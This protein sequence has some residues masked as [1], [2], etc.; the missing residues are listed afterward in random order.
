MRSSVTPVALRIEQIASRQHWIIGFSE[1][2]DVGMPAATIVR[3]AQAGH[4][5]RIHEGVYSTLPPSALTLEGRWLAAVKAC[6]PRAAL[7]HGPSG[8]VHGIVARRE[9]LALHVSLAD[10]SRR[11][12][13]GIVVHR[14][15]HLAPR[16]L[17]TRLSIPTT[18]ATRAV[19]DMAGTDS[20]GSVRRALQQAE[21]F[22]RLDR[23]RLLALASASP[24]RK[25][26]GLI[27]SLLA[28][29]SIPL[30]EVRS[31]LEELLLMVCA[32]HGMPLPAVNVPLLGYEVDFLWERARLVVE[33]DGNDHM[34]VGQRDRDNR[35]DFALQRAGYLVR[36]YSSRDMGRE[37]NVTA[38]VLGILRERWR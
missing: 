12:V 13:P 11:R 32:D 7:S 24:N 22:G 14:P 25:G 31:W 35:R 33:A 34:D 30:S 6:G 4:L 1:L 16:D 10:R 17:T 3:W 28:E 26:A 5:H 15:R 37:A 27:R 36:R 18:T 21:K 20:P 23:P 2:L 8:Q 9:R 38:E 29:R 19:W